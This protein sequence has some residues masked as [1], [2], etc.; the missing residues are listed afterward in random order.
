MVA[1]RSTWDSVREDFELGKY[2]SLIELSQKYGVNYQVLRNKIHKQHWKD[3]LITKRNERLQK[4]EEFKETE[5]QKWVK[6]TVSR[7][8]RYRKDIDSARSQCG[9]DAAGNPLLEPSDLKDFSAVENTMD[10]MARRSLGLSEKVEVTQQLGDSF[11][12]AISKLREDKNTPKLTSA[13]IDRVLEA[14]IID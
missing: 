8:Y 3:P 1:L 7:S 6:E 11:I 2:V 14:E 5:A 9:T 12:S 10:L 4:I 13:D